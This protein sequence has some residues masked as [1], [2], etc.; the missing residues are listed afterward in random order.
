MIRTRKSVLYPILSIGTFAGWG[1]LILDSRTPG[2]GLCLIKRATD[3]PCPSC[4]STRAI[5]LLLKG[6]VLGSLLINPLGI[7]LATALIAIP[8][9][10]TSDVVFR[11]DTLHRAYLGVE[12][13]LRRPFTA[14]ILIV[15]ILLNWMW[16]LH[17]N[18]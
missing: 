1:W 15:L 10:I 3:V 14:G 18:L 2:V 8:L 4:G 16:N 9:W 17:K 5:Q 6:D 13:R 7:V 12:D 11:R